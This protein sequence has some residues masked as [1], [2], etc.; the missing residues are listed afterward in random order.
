MQPRG[1]PQPSNSDN[2]L[3][4]N[5]EPLIVW[6][7]QKRLE[8]GTHRDG[9]RDKIAKGGKMEQKHKHML[10]EFV[11]E[12]ALG[13]GEPQTR[14]KLTCANFEVHWVRRKVGKAP[15]KQQEKAERPKED[16]K[17]RHMLSNED[18]NCKL[19]DGSRKTIKNGHA[20]G[21]TRG[22]IQRQRVKEWNDPYGDSKLCNVEPMCRDIHEIDD[23]V[24]LDHEF[25][26]HDDCRSYDGDIE[27]SGVTKDVLST[28]HNIGF[29]ERSK[30][31]PPLGSANWR[32]QFR[33][34]KRSGRTTTTM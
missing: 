20:E 19:G 34:V 27:Q 13:P 18:P 16:P 30:N 4:L 6:D 9:L 21:H 32:R 28:Q 11:L 10:S 33:R 24:V 26:C 17:H 22:G 15:K 14:K 7:F 3:R 23:H 8:L 31:A 2:P 5:A 12:S 29:E 25:R 1:G